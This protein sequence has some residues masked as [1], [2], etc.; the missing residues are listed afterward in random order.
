MESMAQGRSRLCPHPIANGN[1]L[2]LAIGWASGDDVGSG[3]IARGAGL[4]GEELLP[5]SGILNTDIYRMLYF[6]LFGEQIPREI[7]EKR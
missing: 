7:P 2:P 6:I 1:E 5:T 3:V 4:K